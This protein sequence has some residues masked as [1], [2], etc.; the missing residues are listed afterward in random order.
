MSINSE[1]CHARS[2]FITRGILNR[3]IIPNE[4]VY[5]WVRSKLHNIS[6]ELL[7][8]LPEENSIDILSLDIQASNIIKYLR[9]IQSNESI[10]YLINDQ[11]KVIFNTDNQLL[12]LPV[13]TNLSEESI[14]TNAVGI[15]LITGD[16]MTVSGCEH[17]NKI[18]TNYISSSLVIEDDKGLNSNIIGI[19]TPNRLE[20]AHSKLLGLISSHFI[21]SSEE[22]LSDDTKVYQNDTN[23]SVNTLKHSEKTVE[24][25]REENNVEPSN[26]NECK[27]FTLSV[28][29]AN[30]IRA[31]LE[32]YKWNI[33]KA[34]EALG[35]GRSTLYR[36]M[37]EYDIE[38]K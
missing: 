7:D 8:I 13:F 19:I 26:T 34:S 18:L 3:E 28:V 20:S 37:K 36:K 27:V 17:Y 15:S 31:A 30:T 1:I 14:G 4:I 23:N 32:F 35:I 9:N 10:V 29:E 11:G 22:K 21:K 16:G 25:H 5:S 2:L 6:F 24:I 33:K 38:K 12:E